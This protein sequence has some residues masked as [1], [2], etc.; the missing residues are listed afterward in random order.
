MI[1]RHVVLVAMLVI[2]LLIPPPAA[3]GEPSVEVTAH[4]AGR[5]IPLLDVSGYHCHDLDYP[6]IHCYR[7]DVEVSAAIEP[8]LGLLAV[9]ATS[10]VRVFEHSWYA[11]GSMTI[12]Q[13]YTVLATIGWND[14]ISSFAALNSETGNF[15]WDWFYGGSMPYTFCCNQNVPTL[16]TW[17]D[18]ISSVRRT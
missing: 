5:P 13:D 4:L 10:Y 3:A 16:G 11:G 17:N 8:V 1:R 6:R 9:T 14:R 2:A 15:Y 12:S 18:N 7:T